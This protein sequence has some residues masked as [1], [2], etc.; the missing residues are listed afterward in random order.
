M[1]YPFPSHYPGDVELKTA[2]TKAWEGIIEGMLLGRVVW[3][4]RTKK[5]FDNGPAKIGAQ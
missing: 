2:V 1:S 3:N 4:I 5:L